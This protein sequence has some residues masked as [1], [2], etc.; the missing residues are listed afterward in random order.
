[1]G[2]AAP[3]SRGAGVVER[4]ARPD[5]RGAPGQVRGDPQRHPRSRRDGH[6]RFLRR[7]GCLQHRRR[8]AGAGRP[9][10]G[11]AGRVLAV[12]RALPPGGPPAGGHR[13]RGHRCRGHPADRDRAGGR[14]P[15]RPGVV[16]P[17]RRDLPAREPSVAHGVSARVGAR[18]HE[19]PPRALVEDETLL[20][21]PPEMA[22][23]ARVAGQSLEAAEQEQHQDRQ[24]SAAKDPALRAAEEEG[25]HRER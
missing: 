7:Q 22:V 13:A 12:S 4:G 9:G 16:V 5:S 18:T 17:V 14:D 21:A 25:D 6:R 15:P 2:E 10:A 19:R 3:G 24:A 20:H 23:H 1:M 11:A 8:M